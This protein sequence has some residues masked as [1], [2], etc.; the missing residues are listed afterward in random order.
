MPRADS[1]AGSGEREADHPGHTAAHPWRRWWRGRRR[2]RWWWWWR[3]WRRRRDCSFEIGALRQIETAGNRGIEVV[4][5]SVIQDRRIPAPSSGPHDVSRIVGD[6]ACLRVVR[7]AGRDEPDR[8]EGLVQ[9]REIHDLEAAS[10]KRGVVAGESRAIGCAQVNR[11][12]RPGER[13]GPGAAAAMVVR[14]GAVVIDRVELP[15]R[16]ESG[17][18]QPGLDR[19]SQIDA[20][21]G[22]LR[23]RSTEPV[24]RDVRLALVRVDVEA[25]AAGLSSQ[26]AS[27]SSKPTR[28]AF[29]Q[30]P[31]L[32]HLGRSVARRSRVPGG[33]TDRRDGRSSTAEARP[34]SPRL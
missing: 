12:D 7:R 18:A 1:T 29:R 13:G 4:V 19:I 20:V 21:G 32:D 27:G 34:R 3:R 10:G 16:A 33:R 6:V 9:N 25:V 31:K 15:R 8:V 28:R 30:C 17:R 5:P 23:V 24:E 14:P 11:A 22:Q 26:P 2:R